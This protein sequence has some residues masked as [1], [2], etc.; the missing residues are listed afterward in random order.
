MNRMYSDDWWFWITFNVVAL[1]CLVIG[2]AYFW[3]RPTKSPHP[4]PPP[5]TGEG[6]QG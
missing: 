2:F 3:L 4:S 6:E 1:C 5:Q